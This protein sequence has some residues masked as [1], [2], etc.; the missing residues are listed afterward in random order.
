VLIFFQCIFT[1]ERAHA[2]LEELDGDTEGL[3]E[4]GGDGL[5]LKQLAE[6]WSWDSQVVGAHSKRVCLIV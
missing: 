3:G 5:V 2:K 4:K 1:A 6:S